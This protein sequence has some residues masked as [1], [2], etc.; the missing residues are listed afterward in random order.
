MGRP[1]ASSGNDRC[2]RLSVRDGA[3][4]GH[5]GTG[6]GGFSYAGFSYDGFSYASL[7]YAGRGGASFD[8]VSFSS[9]RLGNSGHSFDH[10][11]Q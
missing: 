4:F 11:S 2:P 8:R 10:A 9:A 3:S 1:A 6:H 7:S 5:G